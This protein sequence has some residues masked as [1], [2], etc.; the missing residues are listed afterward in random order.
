MM[1]GHIRGDEPCVY[2]EYDG[3][4]RE[5]IDRIELP[6]EMRL[7]RETEAGL[8]AYDHRGWYRW[9]R[10]ASRGEPINEREAAAPGTLYASPDD[11]LM[12]EVVDTAGNLVPVELP[13]VGGWGPRSTSPDGRYR[14]VD[15]DISGPREQVSFTDIIQGRV[16]YTP[17][18]HRLG[19]IDLR[20]PS[21]RLAEGVFDNFAT[22][23]VWSHGSQWLVFHAPFMRNRLWA[24]NVVD[25]QL[26]SISFGRRS[27]PSPLANVTDLFDD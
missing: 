24:C 9:Q 22:N 2:V 17:E 18:P 12:A 16:E 27:P 13:I 5:V 1:D 21:L 26:V 14:A 7:R 11:P 3:V 15:I 8:I 4:R 25:A 23:P 10:G 19:L 20:E 6:A